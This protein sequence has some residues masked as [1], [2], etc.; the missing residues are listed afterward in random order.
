MHPGVPLWVPETGG[1]IDPDN[2]AYGL[3]VSVLGGMS[4]G[5]RNRLKNRAHA[6]KSAQALMEGARTGTLGVR[7][8]GGA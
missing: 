1:A 5:G 4:K 8:A 6:A 7:R 2:T 3:I